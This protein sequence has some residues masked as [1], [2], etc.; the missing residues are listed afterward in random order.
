MDKKNI[1]K[2]IVII[3]LI[4]TNIATGYFICVQSE[5][6]VNLQKVIDKQKTNTKVIVF[7]QALIEKVLKSTTPVDFDTRLSLENMVRDINDKSILDAWNS[8]VNSSDS[9]QAQIGIKNLLDLLIKKIN[10]VN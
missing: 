2:N 8:F 6:I 1:L 7:T 10:I 4:L 3:I 5:N 9:N